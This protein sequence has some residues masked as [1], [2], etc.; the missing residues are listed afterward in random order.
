[1]NNEKNNLNEEFQKKLNALIKQ[2]KNLSTTPLNNIS[3]NTYSNE[4]KI[5]NTKNI[6]IY[7]IIS[8]RTKRFN[9]II[10]HPGLNNLDSI[11]LVDNF[12]QLSKLA[13]NSSFCTDIEPT[14]VNKSIKKSDFVVYIFNSNTNE[15]IGFVS[16]IIKD[17]P[18]KSSEYSYFLYIDLICTHPNY[19]GVGS[20]LIEY[21]HKLAVTNEMYKVSLNS[22]PMSVN[23]YK[24]MG[25]TKNILPRG[26]NL[27]SM[28]W[29]RKTER[30][31]TR[32]EYK[33]YMKQTKKQRN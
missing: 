12:Y 10:K 17:L 14:Y 5:I 33:K 25:Y 3:S 20:L 18:V 30:G 15:L 22:V 24:K 32:R 11:D 13:I 23:F 2:Y 1:M 29:F 27:V 4:L 6:D 7:K 16:I 31:G 21:I 26:I 19:K 9:K 8:P 28:S